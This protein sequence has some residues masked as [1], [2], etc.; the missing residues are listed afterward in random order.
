MLRE[1]DALLR[2]LAVRP[3]LAPSPEPE[4]AEELR[5]LVER[6]APELDDFERVDVDLAP[7]LLLLEEAREPV[8]VDRDEAVRDPEELDRAPPLLRRDDV[9]E[10]EPPDESEPPLEPSSAVHFP[11][12]TR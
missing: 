3:E 6:V 2:G 11:D 1:R 7:L 5:P 4:L 8:P 10:E 12:I 9:P